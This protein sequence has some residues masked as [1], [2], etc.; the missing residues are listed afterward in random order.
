MRS[1]HVLFLGGAAILGYVMYERS[2]KSEA[3]DPGAPP[4]PVDPLVVGPAP[5][6]TPPSEMTIQNQ[7]TLLSWFGK[8]AVGANKAT[9]DGQGT[10][11]AAA[12]S[13]PDA[14][15][16]LPAIDLNALLTKVIVDRVQAGQT[17]L[18]PAAYVTLANFGQE[19][20]LPDAVTVLTI[21]ASGV[22]AAKN[23]GWVI[24]MAPKAGT[25]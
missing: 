19:A 2:K 13:K 22:A 18:V 10:V 17:A 23:A 11:Y 24:L 6:S 4:S 14:S 16:N 25:A 5:V 15:G 12:R 1:S 7:N 21:A 20:Q 3:K 8:Y 9:P